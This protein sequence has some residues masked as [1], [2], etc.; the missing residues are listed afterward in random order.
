MPPQFRS[1]LTDGQWERVRSAAFA[2]LTDAEPLR[3]LVDGLRY[4]AAAWCPWSLIPQEF[5]S[6]AELQRYA[7]EWAADGTWLR[8][9]HSLID[10]PP[11]PPPEGRRRRLARV[12]KRIPGVR[13]LLY[14]ARKL[15]Q[16]VQHVRR[17]ATPLAQAPVLFETAFHRMQAGEHAAA[18]DLYT[19]V[20][21]LDPNNGPSLVNRGI[22]HHHLGRLDDAVTDFR[23]ALSV[24]GLSLDT[25]IEANR[26]LARSLLPLGE[27]ERAAGHEYV[28]NLL[29]RFGPAAPWD[30][31]DLAAEADEFELLSEA[32]VELAEDAINYLSDFAVA[33]TMY[34]RRDAVQDEYRR[35]LTTVAQRTRYL[36]GDFVRS[37]GHVAV[38]DFWAKLER[39]GWGDWD[40]LVLLAP[41]EKVANRAYLDYFRPFIKIVANPASAP[42]TR[43]LGTALGTR[44]ATMLELPDE[45][46][47]YFLEAMGAVQETWEK[48][49]RTP[50]LRLTPEDEARGRVKL[51]AMGVP[52]GA[53]FVGLHV[54]T[55]GYYKEAQLGD[56]GQQ[57]AQTHRNAAIADYLPAVE[58]VVRRGGWVIRLGDPSMDPAPAVPGLIDYARGPFKCPRIDVFLCAACRFFMGGPSGLTHLP[59]TFGV[60]CLVTNWVSNALPTY[61][62]RDLFVPKLV[63]S[64]AAGRVLT[65]D[66]MLA[67]STRARSVLATEMDR[68][69]LRPVANTPE[70]LREATT[71]MIDRLDGKSTYTADDEA[72]VSRYAAVA[73]R[74]G[75]VGFS[76]I[77]RDFLRRHQ[78]LLPAA[79]LRKSA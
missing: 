43:H 16:F 46:P 73:R 19:Q 64:D 48:A 29:T 17:R 2:A 40:R 8:V 61:S 21:A 4:R 49:G 5:Q 79:D 72:R 44:V 57:V 25:R 76:R 12:V 62:G 63:R 31:D 36:T 69:G 26:K 22:A 59:T 7:A 9:Q 47:R 14:P 55:S 60:P 23:V 13:T 65:F 15:V 53:W 18:A 50:L 78:H 10:P 41:P 32:N 37:I 67:P 11:T 52:D 66:E 38:L 28:A 33:A 74:N 34:R 58:E 54:R 30:Q 77:G 70:E 68:H 24:P 71:E 20:L 45:P 56:R 1:D 35:W 42:A 39:L 6:S 3:R 27:Y 51:R 75:L